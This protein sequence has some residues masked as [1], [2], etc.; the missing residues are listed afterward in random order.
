VV[1]KAASQKMQAAQQRGDCEA[2]ARQV[3]TARSMPAALKMLF[4][5]WERPLAWPVAALAGLRRRRRRP[6]QAGAREAVSALTLAADTAIRAQTQRYFC[7]LVLLSILEVFWE[8][9][10]LVCPR[11]LSV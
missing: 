3:S 6:P 8:P 5:S 11:E 7:A 9:L 4:F 1:W 10:D 2:A